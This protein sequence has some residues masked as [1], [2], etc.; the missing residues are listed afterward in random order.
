MPASRVVGIKKIG[1]SKTLDITVDNESHLFWAN[2]IAT[3]NSHSVSF[4]YHSYLSAYAKAHFPKTFMAKYLKHA[5]HRL[6]PK[7]EIRQ[8]VQNARQMD[9]E[10]YTNNLTDLNE[11]FAIIKGQIRAGLVDLKNLGKKDYQKICG[12][13]AK[14]DWPE[15][16]PEF[17]VRWSPNIK[18]T[19][20]ESMINGGSLDFLQEPRRKMLFERDIYEQLPSRTKKFI[21][22]NWESFNE[23]DLAGILDRVVEG[24]SGKDKALYNKIGLNKAI[25]LVKSAKNPPYEL[26]YT[27]NQIVALETQIIGA[28]L[29]CSKLDGNMKAA[30]AN[31]TCRDFLKGMGK[32]N[33]VL[34]GVIS[35]VKMHKT[36]KGDPMCFI[37]LEDHSGEIS[38]ILGFSEFLS[39]YSYNL[40]EGLT[41]L[42]KGERPRNAKP[43]DSAL[44]VNELIEI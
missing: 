14:L 30:S 6:K 43:G 2:C 4:A 35:Q 10:I 18:K 25:N 11:E 3:S 34:A 13:K 19:A 8:L 39:K 1:P 7:E 38:S 24:G 22:K 20:V 40:V 29:T 42:L 41:V 16:W 36:K 15:T 33:I 28:P 23:L 5:K 21:E 37:T 31:M 27:T 12:L 9:M 17:M 44:F 32:K 26:K